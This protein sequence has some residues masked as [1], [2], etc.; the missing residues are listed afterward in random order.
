MT[1]NLKDF[2]LAD[3]ST[4]IV[5]NKVHDLG[6]VRIIHLTW[7]ASSAKSEEKIGKQIC[8]ENCSTNYTKI[9]ES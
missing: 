7:V 6:G 8:I 5:M 3:V 2:I 4:Q 1:R 9:L